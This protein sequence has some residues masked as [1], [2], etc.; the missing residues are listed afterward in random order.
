M[1]RLLF[2]DIQKRH[3]PYRF[4]LP[5][6]MPKFDIESNVLDSFHLQK[7]NPFVFVNFSRFINDNKFRGPIGIEQF[8][9]KC[10]NNAEMFIDKDYNII[11][12]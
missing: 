6:E 1:D 4:C 2:C 12:T 10:K 9:R 7:N 11:S 8:F 3:V 5:R